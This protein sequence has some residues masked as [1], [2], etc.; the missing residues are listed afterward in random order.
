[1]RIYT[2][3]EK[4]A[5]VDVDVLKSAMNIGDLKTCITKIIIYNN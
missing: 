1:M 2:Q 5:D 3:F 4:F